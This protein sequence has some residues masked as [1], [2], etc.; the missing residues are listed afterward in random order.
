[1]AVGAKNSVWP[2][3]SLIQKDREARGW[4]Q[5]ALA[6]L[7]GQISVETLRRA[8]S[9]RH[10][11]SSEY[12]SYIAVALDHPV[13]RYVKS[14]LTQYL[15]DYRHL[16]DLVEGDFCESLAARPP[17]SQNLDEKG[18]RGVVH[19]LLDL[20]DSALTKL[21]SIEPHVSLS[22]DL[23][24]LNFRSAEPPMLYCAPVSIRTFVDFLPWLDDV[25]LSHSFNE[26]ML[27][28]IRLLIEHRERLCSGR[29]I[30][31]PSSVVW[32]S[33]GSYPDG[34]PTGA[35]MVFVEN[36]E[37]LLQSGGWKHRRGTET[38]IFA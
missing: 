7:S 27:P 5:E 28:F 2:E 24:R 30:V 31:V 26:G 15:H 18:C 8:E 3:G 9:G 38:L 6:A 14:E 11:I 20:S 36:G 29:L 10:R 17:Q 34:A 25:F 37:L 19:S 13:D 23:D 21:K 35:K 12:I 32:K 4:S 33:D 16:I 1:M 22:D